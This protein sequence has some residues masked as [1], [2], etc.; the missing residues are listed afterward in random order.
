M[1]TFIPGIELSRRFYN[2]VVRPILG[3]HWP[4]LPHAAALVGSGSEALGYDDATSTDHWWGPMVTLFVD[5]GD[6]HL[7]AAIR[8]RM[9]EELPPTV[10]G[11]P[12]NFGDSPADP[13]M[14]VMQFKA[15]APFKHH[16]FVGTVKGFARAVLNWEPDDPLTAADWL[17]FPAQSLLEV[18]AGAVH[19]DGIG[20]LTALRERLVWYP[21]EVWLYLL[22]SGW[23]RIGEEEH[24]MPRAGSRGDELGSAI[25]GSRLARD[26]MMLAFLMDKRYPPYPKWFGTAFMRLDS[27]RRLAPALRQAQ[28]ASGWQTREAALGAAFSIL[29]EMHNALGITEPLPMATSAFFGRPFQVIQG[30][31]F[32]Q[33]IQ[34]QISDAEVQAIAA[35]G[36]IGSIDQFSD[37]TDLHEA[38]HLR[39]AVR[40]LYG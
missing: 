27:A 40:G 11:Y 37:S 26:A 9:A 39:P 7:E 36:L 6:L 18:T 4:G 17:S 25:I 19:H 22:A 16:V 10:A 1:P 20:A 31:R 8:Q 33:A 23:E 2:E 15:E 30:H 5:E 13:G 32:A 24:L 29:A 12:V 14:D 38:A 3:R 34:A 28:T 35:R 21:P